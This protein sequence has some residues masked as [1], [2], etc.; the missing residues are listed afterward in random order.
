MA[1]LWVHVDDGLFT[2]SS[3]RLM[4]LLKSKLNSVLDLKW[5]DKLSSIVGLRVKEVDGG[6]ALDQPM[7]IDKIINMNP[8]N[9]KSRTPLPSSDLVSNPSME[10]DLDYMS[11]IGCLLYLSMGSRPDIT[12]SVNFL[13]RF[14]MAP[15]SS[16]WAALEHLISYL[17][18]S[19]RLTL[20][21]VASDQSQ[22]DITT[23]FNAN[24]GGEGARSVHGFISKLWGA[25]VSWSSKRQTCIARST[26]QAEYMALSFA[27]KDACYISSLLSGFFT[28]PP[29]LIL[30][31]NKAAV[32]I[33]KD[34]RTQKEHRHVDRE[35]HIINELLYKE[36][37]RLEWIS[38]QDQQA[39]I[40]TKALG[41][42]KVSEFLS[43]MGLRLPSHTLASIGGNVCAGCDNHTPPAI[44]RLSP[45]NPNPMFDWFNGG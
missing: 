34:C 26:C 20:P 25:P 19:A 6:F 28:L 4:N 8:S 1:F 15:D 42:R 39:D 40:F 41:W 14:S 33:S 43:Q 37:V 32:H 11:R 31:D 16:H 30:S 13:A 27:S 18:Y 17:R 29:P 36:K 7:L 10:M 9:I 3:T 23:F 21:I 38:T 22:D 24:W 5:D 44:V 45:G 35:F 12:F 2:A